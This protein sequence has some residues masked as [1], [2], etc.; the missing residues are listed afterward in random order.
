MHD[1][2][3]EEEKIVRGQS[4]MRHGRKQGMS[5]PSSEPLTAEGGELD[6]HG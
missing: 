4:V 6:N 3:E 2:G 1:I 5:S